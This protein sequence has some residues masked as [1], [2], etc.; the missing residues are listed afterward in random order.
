[1]K[2]KGCYRVKG[3]VLEER[4]TVCSRGTKAIA[5]SAA[6]TASGRSTL[7]P[8][9]C[10]SVGERGDKMERNKRWI[11]KKEELAEGGGYQSKKNRRKTELAEGG[12]Y[13]TKKRRD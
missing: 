13:Q 11:S 12:G 8:H 7:F 3:N 10:D 9:K 4:E 1:M 5:P 2:R 6:S